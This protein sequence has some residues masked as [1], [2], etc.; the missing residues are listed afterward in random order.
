MRSNIENNM[1]GERI[2]RRVLYVLLSIIIIGFTVFGVREWKSSNE[3]KSDEVNW[4]GTWSTSL[5]APLDVGIS[6]NGFENQTIRL[7]I[8]PQIDGKKMRIRLSN[9]FGSTPLSIEEVHVA[10][11]KSESE[12]VP[13]SDQQVTFGGNPN[14]TIPPGARKFS[15]P[16]SFE[17]TSEKDLVVSL[18][19]RDKT[20][21]ATWHPYSIQTTYIS[22]GNHVSDSGASDF[23]TTETSWFWLDGV[24]VIPD[25]SVKGAI[26]VLGSSIANGNHSTLNANRR[27]PDYLAK[28]LNHETSDTKM[29]VLNAGISANQLIFSTPGKGEHALA[30]IDRDVFSQTGV[31]AVILHLGLNDIR[32]H[33]EYDVEKIIETMKQVIISS[34]EHGLKI[35]GGTLTPFKD[36]GMYTTIKEKTR[37]EVNNWIRNSG[38]FDGVIDFDKALRDPESPEQF[39]TKYDAGDQLHP[40]DAGYK[41]MAES[42]DLSIFK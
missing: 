29:S 40:N 31:K 5:Q 12:I 7:I 21:P 24:D 35:Y 10:V 36:S 22:T 42:I 34:H 37:Q 14:V 41:K 9:T 17:V 30:R 18:Y 39:L 8:H 1:K 16:I 3:K 32:H 26:V 20:G 13:D 38:E 15:D 33:P 27:W 4:V 19:V 2:M 11:S 25:P 28:R 6:H 23:K